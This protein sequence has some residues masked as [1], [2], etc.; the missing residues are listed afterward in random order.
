MRDLRVI[1]AELKSPTHLPLLIAST[2]VDNPVDVALL[3]LQWAFCIDDASIV[4]RK[5]KV[6]SIERQKI[7]DAARRKHSRD[8][9][10]FHEESETV[11]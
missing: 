6:L 2:G 11:T 5:E 4:E 3:T 1:E 7:N 8:L 9:I 10:Q